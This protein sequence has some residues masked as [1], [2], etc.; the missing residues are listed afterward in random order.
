MSQDT[1]EQKKLFRTVQIITWIIL[2][3]LPVVY[4]VIAWYMRITRLAP[5]EYDQFMIYLLLIVAILLPIMIPVLERSQIKSLRSNPDA[6]LVAGRLFQAL[7]ITRAALIEI[8]Y[9]LGI[10]TFFITGDLLQMI[11]FYPI[12]IIWSILFWPRQAGFQR[13]IEKLS[14]T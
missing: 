8:V 11:W 9:L 7:S 5:K 10:V 3:G 14:M 12:G 4:L 1:P 13:L 6:I 2:V